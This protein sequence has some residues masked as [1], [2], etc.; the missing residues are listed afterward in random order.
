LIEGRLYWHLFGTGRPFRRL[1]PSLMVPAM[2]LEDST[3]LS[4]KS[5]IAAAI[6]KLVREDEQ[7]RALAR[8]I[9]APEAQSILIAA[10]MQLSEF[11]SQLCLAWAPHLRSLIPLARSVATVLSELRAPDYELVLIEVGAYE[12]DEA[13][14][15]SIWAT[16]TA[17]QNARE[18]DRQ[19]RK[20]G[21]ALRELMKVAGRSTL[22]VS[23]RAKR[24][25]PLL[26]EWTRGLIEEAIA[27]SRLRLSFDE[28]L[29]ITGKAAERQS[30]ACAELADIAPL[31][32][33]SVPKAR[34]G[35]LSVITVAHAQLLMALREAG[36]S[37]S[38]TY[39]DIEEDYTDQMTTA[40]RRHFQR[41]RFC[42]VGSRHLLDRITPTES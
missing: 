14:L 25:L 28:F 18:L 8:R 22:V 9:S 4:R 32:F 5:E 1:K 35:S 3:A 38:F 37:A 23:R 33:N 11:A 42:P 12:P 6:E 13:R 31:I 34:G 21:S 7:W 29:D 30:A 15:L 10:G 41:P 16:S 17:E 26:N 19:R 27:G 39:S 20:L 36:C 40:T 24:L 2:G